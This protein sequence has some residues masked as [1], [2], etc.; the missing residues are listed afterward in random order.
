M[1]HG[2]GHGGIGAL[3]G[4]HPQITELGHFR[5]IGRDGHDLGALVAH[6]GQEVRIGRAC[7]G[8]VGAPGN[9]EAAVV[10]VGRFGHVGLLTPDLRAGRGQIAIPVVKAHADAT[11]QAEV[12]AAGGVADHAHR[13]NGRE[14]D[15]AVRAMLLD[16]V[17]VGRR[18]HLVD[19]IPGA[20]HKATQAALLL[21]LAFGRFVFN[22]VR[23]GI[24]R[25]LGQQEGGAPVLEQAAAHHGVLHTVGAVQVPAVA[26]AARAAT[27]FVVGKIGAGAGVVGLLGFPGDDTALDVNL[28]RART[29]AVHAVGAAHDLVVRPAVA[30]GVFPG[31]VFTVGLA[32]ALRKGLARLRKVRKTIEEMAHRGLLFLSVRW[33]VSKA[34]RHACGRSTTR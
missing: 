11:D 27:G 21:P 33:A 31:A 7:L 32:V 34:S 23:P 9:D 26:G 29:R 15:D 8:H 5:V 17:D 16:R 6:F 2:H 1:A 13:R 25:A 4:V 24:H 3:L 12:A 22:D 18:D 30:V 19:L 10:P 20:A 14:T 28:P